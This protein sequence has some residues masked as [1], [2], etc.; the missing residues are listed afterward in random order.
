MTKPI[1]WL[2]YA[3][4]ILVISSEYSRDRGNYRF[5]VLQNLPGQNVIVSGHWYQTIIRDRLFAS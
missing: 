2:R 3:D 1:V 4:D 5:I